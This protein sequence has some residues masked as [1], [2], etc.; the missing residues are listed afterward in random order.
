MATKAH[1][2]VFSFGAYPKRL[3]G[4]APLFLIEYNT[5]RIFCKAFFDLTNI[6]LRDILEI[7]Y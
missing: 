1:I 6:A 4:L 3:Y 2:N 5:E 7:R